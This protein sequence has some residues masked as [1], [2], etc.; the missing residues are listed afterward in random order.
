MITGSAVPLSNTTFEVQQ[1]PLKLALSVGG[2]SRVLIWADCANGNS[3]APCTPVAPPFLTRTLTDAGIPWTLVG[4]QD[5]ALAALRT[6]A[7]DE[8]VI[9]QKGPYEAK[10]FEELTE[11]IRGGL[12]LLLG[13]VG[14]GVVVLRN[15]LERRNELAVLLAVGFR[16]GAIK[17]LVVHEHGALL[18]AGLGLGVL[19]A[20][21]AVRVVSAESR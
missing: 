13:S 2:P 20:V 6:G 10:V 11:S 19:A 12:G 8:V 9:D 3:S 7:F 4:T 21:V 5:Q 17:R 1:P 16:R 18:L 14:L 15:V